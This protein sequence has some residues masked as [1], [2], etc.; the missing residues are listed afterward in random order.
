MGQIDATESHDAE[1]QEIEELNCLFVPLHDSALLVPMSA[2]AE[3]IQTVNVDVANNAPAWFDGW[4]EW[5]QKRVPLISFEAFEPDSKP[6][7]VSKNAT[8][9]VMNTLSA[10]KGLS[11]YALQTQGFSHLIRLSEDDHLSLVESHSELPHVLM[12]VDL[13]GRILQVPNLESLEVYLAESL[14]QLI[15]KG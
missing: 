6:K 3:V 14:Q 9:L 7:G 8:A 13:D 4:L 10:E 1:R 2:V 15:K 12:D 5:R 11:Y